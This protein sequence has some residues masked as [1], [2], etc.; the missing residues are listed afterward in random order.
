MV[1]YDYKALVNE[2]THKGISLFENRDDWQR[3]AQALSDLGEDGRPLFHAIASL[4]DSYKKRE[5]D[6]QFNDALRTTQRVHIATFIYMCN[7]KGVDTK[8]FIIHNDSPKPGTKLSTV[9]CE[10]RTAKPN[11]LCFISSELV[12]RSLDMQLKSNF[13]AALCRMYNNAKAIREV[14]LKYAL[15]VT[16]DSS[17]IFWQ[18]DELGRVRS[19]KVMNY[20]WNGH[21]DKSKDDGKTTWVHSIMKEQHTIPANWHLTQCLFGAHLL[22]PS[23]MSDGKVIG[24]VESEKSAIF[25][26]LAY[27]QYIWVAC[28]GFG[29]EKAGDKHK[30]LV[31]RKVVMFP[32][33]HPDG[34]FYKR[35]CEIAK[36][37]KKEGIDVTVSDILEQKATAEE[38]AA[39]ID[40]ADWIEGD[41]RASYVPSPI[42]YLTEPTEQERI[43][44]AMAANDANLRTLINNLKLQIVYE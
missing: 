22:H 4:A 21:R 25:C 35:W 43:L 16:K 11:E 31:G 19:G 41:F 42:E 5:N 44:E 2:I 27:P 30:V 6:Y 9:K 8:K 34:R 13:Q 18:I 36:E 39:K 10:T 37:W 40:I 23:F 12:A 29:Q 26:S 28:G 7:Q 20:D 14:C 17:V 24:F 1:E 33:A 15:G 38:K 3:G 32:D